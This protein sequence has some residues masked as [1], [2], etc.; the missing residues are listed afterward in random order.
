MWI[1]VAKHTIKTD[2]RQRRAWVFC[3]WKEN[4]DLPRTG[5]ERYLAEIYTEMRFFS[6]KAP[7]FLRNVRW[8][9]KTDYQKQT[10][11]KEEPGFFYCWKENLDLPR[12]GKERDLDEIYTNIVSFRGRRPP[13]LRM[14]AAMLQNTLP[15]TDERRQKTW[16]FYCWK[17]KSDLPPTGKERDLAEIYTNMCLASLE[18]PP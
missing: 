11:D 12:T 13:R 8:C 17:E 2:D 4:L 1:D 10:N 15:K 18:G 7:V 9:R 5:K 6:Q 16:G 3:S 14:V